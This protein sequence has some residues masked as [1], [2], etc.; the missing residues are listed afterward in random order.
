[1][2]SG[3]DQ[4]ALLFALVPVVRGPALQ[5]EALVAIAAIDIALLVDLQPDARMAER[6]RNVRG[7]VAGDARAFGVG[8]FGREGIIVGHG[9]ALAKD[10]G[11]RQTG[12]RGYALAP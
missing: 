9:R 7:A 12:K 10:I 8:D 5:D 4:H 1:M 2:S 11:L 6:G 3:P